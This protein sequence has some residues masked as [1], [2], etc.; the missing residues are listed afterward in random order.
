MLSLL[1]LVAVQA[2]AKA[3]IQKQYDAWSKAYMARD[4]ET[5]VGILSPDY[6]LITSTKKTLV[7]DV[8]VAK[9]KLMKDAAPD[10]T[11]YST[12]IKKLSLRG[13]EADVVAVET[14]ESPGKD[15]KSGKSA[16]VLH[17]HEYL[18]TWIHYDAGWRLRRTE[19]RKET[20]AY[21]IP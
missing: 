13:E 19:T 3:E 2:G 15:P 21:R 4:C 18:D 20:T 6:K 11:K 5:L 16:T 9:L 8:Y 7:Y 1:F 12:E 10:P 17:R 14:M